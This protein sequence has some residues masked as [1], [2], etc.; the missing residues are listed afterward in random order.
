MGDKGQVNLH[1]QIC[2]L[3]VLWCGLIAMK[4][5]ENGLGFETQVLN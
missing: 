5:W 2:S 1:A 4:V 3:S